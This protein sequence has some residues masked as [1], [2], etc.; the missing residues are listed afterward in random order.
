MQSMGSLGLISLFTD[1]FFLQCFYF[2]W[3]RENN[4]FLSF[5]S[6]TPLRFKSFTSAMCRVNIL[7]SFRSRWA[8]DKVQCHKPHKPQNRRFVVRLGFDCQPLFKK[9]RWGDEPKVNP[10][11]KQAPGNFCIDRNVNFPSMFF[12][13]NIACSTGSA[14]NSWRI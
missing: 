11:A 2:C 9:V 4:S 1:F 7:L 10:S 12:K 5:P 14:Q 8:Q 6:P 13:G 3:A